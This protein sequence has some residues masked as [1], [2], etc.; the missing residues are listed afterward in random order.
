M[1]SKQETFAALLTTRPA[2]LRTKERVVAWLH[3]SNA[4]ESLDSAHDDLE[5]PLHPA[6]GDLEDSSQASEHI[7]AP[8][9]AETAPASPQIS[10]EVFDSMYPASREAPSRDA[11]LAEVLAL[12]DNE[13]ASDLSQA[14]RL[15][16]ALLST[17]QG[18]QTDAETEDTLSCSTDTLVEI[19]DGVPGMTLEEM[20]E[21]TDELLDEVVDWMHQVGGFEFVDGVPM[22]PH[23]VS[24]ADPSDGFEAPAGS[25][26]EFEE[27]PFDPADFLQWMH[28]E[29]FVVS[30]DSDGTMRDDAASSTSED[31]QSTDSGSNLQATE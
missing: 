10:S 14:E 19:F 9:D 3:S 27:V 22:D 4:G 24:A 21:R 1:A 15:H 23:V 31:L 12:D 2:P 11:L 28:R 8:E 25:E 5:E 6:Q 18:S 29:Y 26:P 16:P 7:Q 13:S 30:S 17:T 20:L